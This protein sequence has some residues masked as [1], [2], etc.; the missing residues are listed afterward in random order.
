MRIESAQNVFPLTGYTDR[1]RFDCHLL[2][3]G[4]PIAKTKL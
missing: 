1:K 4:H 3:I 2:L